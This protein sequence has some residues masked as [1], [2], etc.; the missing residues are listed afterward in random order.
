MVSEL[1]VVLTALSAGIVSGIWTPLLAWLSSDEP[2]NAKKFV[3]GFMTC[4]AASLGFSLLALQ[5]PPSDGVIALVTFW[6]EIFMSAIGVDYTRNKIGGMT[7]TQ[8]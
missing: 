7:R 3:Q 4:V 5:S 8:Q 1:V 6:L 2:F